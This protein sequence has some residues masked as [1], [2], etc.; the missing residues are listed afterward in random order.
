MFFRRTAGAA[1]CGMLY[2]IGECIGAYHGI[3]E[4]SEN[5]RDAI[6]QAIAECK[7]NSETEE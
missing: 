3:L 2:K 7:E 6:D 5:W 1:M 4:T